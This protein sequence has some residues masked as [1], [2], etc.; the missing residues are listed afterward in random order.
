MTRKPRPLDGVMH[1]IRMARSIAI[2]CHISPDG[3][4]IGSALALRLGL[5]ELGTEVKLYC[6]DKIPELLSFLPGAD[7]FRQPEEA[8]EEAA[9]EEAEPE[10]SAEQQ[11]L[12][13]IRDLLKEK[14]K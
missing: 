13:E 1:S 14:N 9:E 11:L 4:T 8:E 7:E 3:D 6:Q 2:V 5:L 12:T 10:M